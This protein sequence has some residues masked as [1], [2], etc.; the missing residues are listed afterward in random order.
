MSV[1]RELFGTTADG[2]AIDR[3]ILTNAN[4]VE[5]AIMTYG[6]TLVGLRAPDRCGR[7]EDV[8]LG[9]DTLAQYLGDHPYFGALIG[10]YGNRIANG[11]F[12]LRGVEYT[13]ACNNGPNHLHGGPNGFHRAIWQAQ[14]HTVDT[15][16]TLALTYHSRDGEEGYP[17]NLHV[18]VVYT[19][20][21][22]NQLRIDYSATTDQA[23]IVNLTNHAYFNLA[24][25]GDILEHQLQLRATHFLPINSTLIPTGELR[26]VVGTPMDF[27][28]PT[29]IGARI[30]SDDQQL[31]YALDGYDHCWVIDRGGAALAL[32]AH[33]TE[34]STGR[35]MDVYTTQPG[36]QFYSGN[37]LDGSLT[38]K[39][40]QAYVRHTGFCLETQHFPDSPNQPQFPST[41]L[42][43]GETYQHTT[44]YQFS[45][46]E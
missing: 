6:G 10:R 26:P 35:V 42:E 28:T 17:G 5:A 41:V 12:Q 24:G 18:T 38:G 14:A 37:F 44:I 16:P 46:E 3:Y 39:R 25:A 36:I 29:A 11:H 8:V 4:G 20:D 22:Q 21:D 34:T 32:A 30:A 1:T 19:L 7:L 43:P 9:F 23:T 13:L 33:V 15:A 27:T 2:V 40:G 31:H 45:V